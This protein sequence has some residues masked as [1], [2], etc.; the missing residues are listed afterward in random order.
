MRFI[1]SVA[2]KHLDFIE[3]FIS[4]VW[5]D[6]ICFLTT[7]NKIETF[8]GHLGRVFFTHGSA[9]KVSTAERVSGNELRSILNLLLID[10]NAV[11]IA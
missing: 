2:S 4:E 1:K 9:E 11:S 8:L 7:F 5:L 6:I 3:E 10:H